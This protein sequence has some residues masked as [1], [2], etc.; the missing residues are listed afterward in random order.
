M[1]TIDSNLSPQAGDMYIKE[2]GTRI[3]ILDISYEQVLI[4]GRSGVY[5]ITLVNANRVEAVKVIE[6]PGYVT[7]K[8]AH[9]EVSK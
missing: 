6:F 4:C 7:W 9:T 2:D 3:N 1:N 5:G 8:L